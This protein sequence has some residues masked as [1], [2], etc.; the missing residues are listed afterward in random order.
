MVPRMPWRGKRKGARPEQQLEAATIARASDAAAAE[1]AVR[2]AV[3]R[4]E[5]ERPIESLVVVDLHGEELAGQ[6]GALLDARVVPA[7]AIGDADGVVAV[8]SSARP[9]DEVVAALDPLQS[10]LLGV[11]LVE[12]AHAAP[13]AEEPDA[14]ARSEPVDENHALAALAELERAA[15]AHGAPPAP[16]PHA[17]PAPPQVEE[18]PATA[19][20]DR[21]EREDEL[22]RRLTEL[23]HR[24]AALRRMVE[25][26]ERQRTKLEER[27]QALASAS[28]DADERDA[29]LSEATRRAEAAEEHA[30]T[31]ERRVAELQEQL[32]AAQAAAAAAAAPPQP[33]PVEPSPPPSAAPETAAE[34]A[35][36][37]APSS[38][39]G[40]YTL[41]QLEHAI[42]DAQVRG[43]PQ[44]E[45]WVFYLPLLREHARIDGTIP[46]QFDSL[47]DSVFGPSL[48]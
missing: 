30:R 14:S 3:A 20:A 31:L 34:P 33:A 38:E 25:A 27:E 4:T 45:E 19:D 22:A 42:A 32:D 17:D 15:G 29:R 40:A 36:S 35:L 46:A 47:I 21:Q 2:S 12:A 13:A 28:G 9:A 48:G 26:I 7:D 8:A 44:A 6:L 1:V 11:V 5:L 24:E 16:T 37:T 10:V 41:Q 23:T 39:S 18:E 43:E